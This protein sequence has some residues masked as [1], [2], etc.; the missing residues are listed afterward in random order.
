MTPLQQPPGF[1]RLALFGDLDA[2]DGTR[3]IAWD[4]NVILLPGPNP[5]LIVGTDGRIV[6]AI[7]AGVVGVGRRGLCV[8]GVAW[9][10]S[11]QTSVYLGLPEVAS[12]AG[13]PT[14]GRLAV[15]AGASSMLDDG[16]RFIYASRSAAASASLTM[17]SFS[18]RSI[19][20]R[21]QR[22]NWLLGS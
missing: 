7:N 18:V 5:T 20:P 15:T 6:T 8:L 3:D 4:S 14:S 13:A 21:C 10:P 1:D 17:L 19:S 2:E 16:G 11:P 9:P 12:R 22:S